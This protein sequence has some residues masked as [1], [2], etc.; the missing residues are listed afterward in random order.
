[1]LEFISSVYFLGIILMAGACG[2]FLS[3]FFPSWYAGYPRRFWKARLTYKDD[4]DQ[5]SVARFSWFAAWILA[6]IGS[7]L[8]AWNMESIPHTFWWITA[9][10]LYGIV[11]IWLLAKA[12]VALCILV[13]YIGYGII[14]L[15]RWIFNDKPLFPKHEKIKS[16]LKR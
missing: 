11:V 8:A 12:I 2:L 15:K 7:L 16:L 10:T 1:M 3:V 4:K 5:Q 14:R 6:F 9:Q 13:Q